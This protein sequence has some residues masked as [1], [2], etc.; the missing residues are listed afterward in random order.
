MNY[1]GTIPAAQPVVAAALKAGFTRHGDAA[2]VGTK[3]REG[4]HVRISRAGGDGT[5]A[6]DTAGFLFECYD[7][8]EAA[9]ERLSLLV[10]R[11]MKESRGQYFAGGFITGW[12][13]TSGP[14]S[15]EDPTTTNPRFQLTGD[16]TLLID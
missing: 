9:A 3:F 14:V 1:Y 13:R 4:R 10:E 7:P 11:V 12:R 8:N 15:F 2:T 5:F 16:L 6:T